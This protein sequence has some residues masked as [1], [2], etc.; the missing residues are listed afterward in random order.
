MDL[1]PEKIWYKQVE[2]NNGVLNGW[3]IGELVNC[4]TERK[5]DFYVC[6]PYSLINGVIG[7]SWPIDSR[8]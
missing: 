2:V 8:N 1:K 3:I 6:K 4:N 5:A 7:I